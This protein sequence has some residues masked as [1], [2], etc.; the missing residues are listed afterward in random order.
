MGQGNPPSGGPGLLSLPVC[1]FPLPSLSYF[2]GISSLCTFTHTQSDTLGSLACWC[3]GSGGGGS[4]SSS[5]SGWRSIRTA[6]PPTWWGGARVSPG[7]Y[8][9][10][11]EEGGQASGRAARENTAKLAGC[12]F[13]GPPLHRVGLHMGKCVHRIDSLGIAQTR[14]WRLPVRLKLNFF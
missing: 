4:L 1:R 8:L 10:E 3:A 9:G 12:P 7:N 14:N 11:G 6:H 13:I 2:K 5:L